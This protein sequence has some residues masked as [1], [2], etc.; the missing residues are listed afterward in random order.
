MLTVFEILVSYHYQ[1]EGPGDGG[2]WGYNKESLTV[3]H[4]G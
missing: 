3:D 1:F 2:L 4:N